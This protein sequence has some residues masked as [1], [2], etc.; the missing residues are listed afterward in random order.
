MTEW[1][2]ER[3][4]WCPHLDCLFRRRAMDSICGGELPEPEPHG[5]DENTHR[6]C[7][8]CYD[9]SGDVFDL[10]VNAGDLGWFRWIFD[11]L[12]GLETSWL[13]RPR[14]RQELRMM[15]FIEALE[16]ER[17]ARLWDMRRMP[18]GFWPPFLEAWNR[19]H[20]ED[21]LTIEAARTRLSRARRH[22]ERRS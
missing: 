10:Q 5:A 16:D 19:E 15:A 3:P 8:N 1:E 12:D 18:R 9:H 17:G 4:E 20:P 2:Q 21:P 11:A 6:F 14:G 7:L 13:S 22:H